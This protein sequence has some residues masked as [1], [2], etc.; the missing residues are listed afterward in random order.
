M[1]P[2]DLA[3]QLASAR[4]LGKQIDYALM[5]GLQNESDAYQLQ[6]LAAEHYGSRHIGYKVGATNE[7]SQ[8][9]FGC[10]EPFF[11]PM[12]DC[13]YY[14]HGATFD[15]S[16]GLLGGE[17]EFAFLIDRDIPDTDLTSAQITDYIAAAHVA[18]E[19]IGRRSAGK[20]LP[21]LYAAIADFG[22]NAA[23]IRGPSIT[24]WRGMDLAEVKVVAHTNGEETNAGDG[25]AVLGNPLNS[26]VWLHDNL[27]AR[28]RS[29][30][31]GQWITTGT[32]LGVIQA[33]AD[34]SVHVD[35]EGCG[36]VAYNLR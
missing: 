30:Q 32:C 10:S 21:S 13:D 16:D 24:D 9:L 23:F 1:S 28:G 4:Q 17:A 7:T 34:S 33:V 20:G 22:G 26:L 18:V 8:K 14:E 2:S 12:F 11:G 3:Q 6:E 35:F 25:G 27:R 29:L 19:L 5:D 36:E 15:L 31:A